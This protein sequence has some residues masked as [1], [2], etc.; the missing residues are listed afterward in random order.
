MTGSQDFSTLFY[1]LSQYAPGTPS[2]APNFVK[3]A[4]GFVS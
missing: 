2:P 3:I 1:S 4:R